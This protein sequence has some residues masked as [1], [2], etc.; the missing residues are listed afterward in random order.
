MGLG[1]TLD[2][3]QVLIKDAL[4]KDKSGLQLGLNSA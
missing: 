3:A 4:V 1:M 2:E